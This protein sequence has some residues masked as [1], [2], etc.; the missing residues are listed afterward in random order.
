MIKGFFKLISGLALLVSYHSSIAAVLDFTDN[1]LIGS[2]S[3]VTDGYRGTIDGVGFTLTSTDGTVNFNENYDGSLST[4]CGILA[5]DKDGAGIDNDEISPN[6]TLTLTFDSIVSF[7]AFHFLDLY[8]GIGTEQATITLDGSLLS[9]MSATETSGQGGYARLELLGPMTGQI[10]EFTA[11]LGG[12]LKDDS[13]NDY[14][15]AGVTVSAVPVPAAIW[16]FGSAIVGLFGFRRTT[17]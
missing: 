10:L 3:S 1:S 13:N 12:L 2:L 4:G 6:Q 8:D 16:L 11:A 7:T 5:C 9:Y 17:K 14:A 15:F